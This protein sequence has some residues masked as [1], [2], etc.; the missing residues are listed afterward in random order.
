MRMSG[1]GRADL[2]RKEI[3]C[4]GVATWVTQFAHCTCFDLANSFTGEIEVIAHFFK[5]AWFAFTVESE[6]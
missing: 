6:S 5:R 3:A 2:D 1:S 4:T